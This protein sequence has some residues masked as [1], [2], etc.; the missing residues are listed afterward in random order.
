MPTLTPYLRASRCTETPEAASGA[1]ASFAVIAQLPPHTFSASPSAELD[2][3]WES[4]DAEW[5]RAMEREPLATQW[6][7]A[8]QAGNRA[9]LAMLAGA[10]HISS[11]LPHQGIVD[12]TVELT[13]A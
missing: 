2:F 11:S 5:T 12:V 3:A 4:G 9:S 7:T 13:A 8:V 6:R 1:G 10:G